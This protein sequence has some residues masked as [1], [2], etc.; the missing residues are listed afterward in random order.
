MLEL[1][2]DMKELKNDIVK[3]THIYADAINEKLKKQMMDI[4][5]TLTLALTSMQQLMGVGKS[6]LLLKHQQKCGVT[7]NRQDTK[8]YLPKYYSMKINVY[9]CVQY[10]HTTINTIYYTK[11]II[12]Y[13]KTICHTNIKYSLHTQINKIH[14]KRPITIYSYQNTI[15]QTIV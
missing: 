6:N 14:N 10:I 2:K 5:S 9:V 3:E 7:T 13:P 1:H 11:G 15:L 4:Q 8:K 12:Q